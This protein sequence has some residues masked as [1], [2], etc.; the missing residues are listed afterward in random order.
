MDMN[1]MNFMG[2]MNTWGPPG[3]PTPGSSS[4]HGWKPNWLGFPARFA[5]E[6][7]QP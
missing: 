3:N 1:Y 7:K 6:T 5:K 2:S 4:I